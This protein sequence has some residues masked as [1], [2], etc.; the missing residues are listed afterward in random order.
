MNLI[1]LL[2]VES[3][4]YRALE[5]MM[6]WIYSFGRFICTVFKI[7]GRRDYYVSYGHYGGWDWDSENIILHHSVF[8]SIFTLVNITITKKMGFPKM[9][10]PQIIH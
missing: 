1:P 6:Y 7:E 10:V 4:F 5:C 2:P 8:K 9:G 3:L